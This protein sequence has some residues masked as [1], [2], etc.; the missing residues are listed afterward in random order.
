MFELKQYG[1]TVLRGNSAREVLHMIKTQPGLT[2]DLALIDVVMPE[3][4]GL[5][6]GQRLREIYPRCR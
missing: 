4:D 5:E 6:L 3:M 2:I 1:Y